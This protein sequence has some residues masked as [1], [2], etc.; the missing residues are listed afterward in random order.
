MEKALYQKLKLGIFVIL[1]TILFVLSVYLI[2][3]K[4]NMFGNTWD[5]Y[6]SFYDVNG[7]RPGNNV[8]YSGIN[9]GTVKEI[10]MVSD[11]HIIIKIAIEKN[12]TQHIKK[13]A[14]C[15]I[16]PDGLVGSMIVNILPG[17]HSQMSIENGDTIRSDSRIRT[18]E[19]LQT[20]SV[21]NENAA[22][23]TGEL[24]MITK[25]I[26][27][28]K[29]LLGSLLKDTLL[30]QDVKDIISH[31]KNT[32]LA[33]ETTVNHLNKI[34]SSLDQKDNLVGLMKDTATASKVKNII[35]DVEKSS[36]DL[37]TLM[38]NL[39]NT[40]LNAHETISNI[41]DGKG[42]LNYLSN[43][44]DLVDKINQTFIHL[45][46]TVLQI[47]RAGLKLNENLEALKSTWLLRGH[48]KRLE[49]EKSQR[50]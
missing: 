40:I 45:D 26:S 38:R 42:V 17:E 29:G 23:L 7:L 34:L 5:I 22:L 19:M 33:A 32:S 15:A 6:V 13:D 36:K 46:S 11:T 3:N 44:A 10:V 1:A 31:V 30:T 39:D 27:S 8:R 47:D 48:F 16:T 2:G 25:E 28:G 50:D 24:L 20:L 21:T 14:K 35:A 41:K 9:V 4:Q 37:Q 18:N 43:D 12:I 49:K